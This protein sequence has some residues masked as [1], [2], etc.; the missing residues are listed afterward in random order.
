MERLAGMDVANWTGENAV[1]IGGSIGGLLAARVLSEQGMRVTVVDRDEMPTV[2]VH[3]KG[4]PQSRHTHGLLARGFQIFEELLP[5]LGA[6]L[7]ERGALE[8][9][10]Q[11]DVVWYSD[12]YLINRKPSN[13]NVL[14]VSRPTLEA[15]VRSRVTALPDVTILA[16]TEAL[17]LVQDHGRITGV[18]ISGPHLTTTLPARVVVDATGRSNRGPAWL[19]ELGYPE[20]AEDVVKANLVYVSREYRRVPGAQDFTGIIHSHYPGNPVGG[21]TLATD[22][23]RWLV[24]MLGFG[25][26]SPPTVDGEFEDFAQR[27]AGEELYGL[28]TTAEPITEL[29]R[30]RI[31]PSVR[32]RYE[33]SARL[34]EGYVALGDSLCC[35][36]PAYGQGMTTAAMTA[37]WLRTCLSRGSA[38]LTRR[39]FKGVA[40]I[41]DVPWDIT[42][43]NDLRFPE[44]VGPRPA[45]LRIL[46]AY[47][48]K[49]FRAGSRDPEVGRTF[50]NVAN[51]LVPPQRLIS[52][53]ML[54]RVWRGR[55]GRP[56][57]TLVR[58]RV[59]V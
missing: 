10:M 33:R 19:A 22:G 30:F 18:R 2:P 56:T 35:F 42:V 4:V 9:D 50:L 24:T 20:V 14:L 27:L 29:T 21:G 32:R 28:V 54:F 46:N 26:N 31:G 36:N 44:V 52:P 41:I 39:Y 12:G 37:L 13:L 47:M 17:G 25:D 16:H 34:P 7:T 43:G 11:R 53:G 8:S 1:V 59:P 55:R 23:N 57:P 3:R 38:G 51:F 58:T 15:Y 5:G 48:A 45:R 49:L 6:D 40:R